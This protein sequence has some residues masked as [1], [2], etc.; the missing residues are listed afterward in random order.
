MADWIADNRNKRLFLT[1]NHP[2]SI[3]FAELSRRVMQHLD[4]PSGD[5]PW[6][7]YNEANLPCEVPVS[8]H[9]IN[10]F[11]WREKESQ[12]APHYYRG[13]LEKA[14]QLANAVV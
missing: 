5:I 2:C 1:Y 11:G 7:H 12:H 4:L 10:T 6:T 13:L 3:L 8:R 14:W 9:V